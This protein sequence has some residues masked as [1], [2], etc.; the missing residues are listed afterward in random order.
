M[1]IFSRSTIRPFKAPSAADKRLQLEEV[2]TYFGVNVNTLP[3]KESV[4]SIKRNQAMDLLSE[5]GIRVVCLARVASSTAVVV[6]GCNN[7]SPGLMKK[8]GFLNGRF[9]RL[10]CNSSTTNKAAVPEYGK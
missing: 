6:T 3:S 2:L 7:F 1:T 9:Y 10:D 8:I 5:Y 4:S